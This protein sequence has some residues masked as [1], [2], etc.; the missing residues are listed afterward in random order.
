[1]A[2]LS[3]SQLKA[4]VKECLVEIL[5]EGIGGERKSSPAKALYR[6]K[7][8]ISQPHQ[9]EPENRRLETAINET[10]KSMTSD[11]I[12]ASVLADT[13]KTTLQEQYRVDRM[14][15]S[16]DGGIPERPAGQVDLD[17]FG[18][19]VKNWEALAFTEKK[20]P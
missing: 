1:M 3:K 16:S 7:K 14:N 10:V 12:L 11:D 4:I 6:A 9:P 2:K 13:A 19:A 17:I 20:S 18:D 8:S 15:M 5:E